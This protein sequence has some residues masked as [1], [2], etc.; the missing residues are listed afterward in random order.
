M[1]ILRR[2]NGA[3]TTMGPNTAGDHSEAYGSAWG[4]RTWEYPLTPIGLVRKDIEKLLN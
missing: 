4:L 1:Q 2:C 3:G